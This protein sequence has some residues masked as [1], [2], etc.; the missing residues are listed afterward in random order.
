MLKV[1][2]CKYPVTTAGPN[3]RA[4]FIDE[5]VYGICTNTHTRRE[6]VLK[7]FSDV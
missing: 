7:L 5:P 6:K 4:G 1:L 2:I 3:A